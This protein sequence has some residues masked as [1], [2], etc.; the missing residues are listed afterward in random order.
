MLLFCFRE[1]ALPQYSFHV[2]L[3]K[4]EEKPQLRTI[5]QE[6]GNYVKIYLVLVDIQCSIFRLAV[7][8]E[9]MEVLS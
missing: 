2:D 5:N 4:H 6:P 8:K 1:S 3:Q 9:N 7:F